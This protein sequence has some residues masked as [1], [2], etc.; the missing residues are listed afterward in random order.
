MFRDGSIQ[1]AKESLCE[2]EPEVPVC[3]LGDPA[4]PLLPFSMKEFSK[5]ERILVNV[6]L[7]NVIRSKN[8][9]RVR[10]WAIKT[11]VWLFKKR[12]GHKS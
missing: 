6:F 7:V 1:N 4:Y 3:I 5:G 12:N 10:I 9:Y 2:G 11:T 8:G